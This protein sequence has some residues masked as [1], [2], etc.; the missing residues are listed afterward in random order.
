MMSSIEEIITLINEMRQTNN[1]NKSD[2]LNV[3]A[4]SIVI[5]ANE[6]LEVFL[7]EEVD[8]TKV[9]SELADVLMYAF[10]LAVDL[11]LD[12]KEII[13]EKIA[14]VNQRDYEY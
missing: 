3:L 13:K 8:L 14:E 5:E 10:S 11:D 1:W 6:L 4:K 9:Q 2:T 12:I 7:A